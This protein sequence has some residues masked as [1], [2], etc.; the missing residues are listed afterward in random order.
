MA[1]PT[2]TTLPETPVRGEDR[3]AFATKANAFLGALPT[4]QAEANTLGSYVETKAAEVE[5]DAAQVAT[6]REAVEVA[7]AAGEGYSKT[8]VELGGDFDVGQ[9][10]KCVRVGDVVTITGVGERLTH[11]SLNTPLS[12]DGVIPV[13]FRPSF[14]V[15]NTYAVLN[16]SGL[17][18][19]SVRITQSGQLSL[20]YLSETGGVARTNSELPPTISYSKN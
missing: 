19:L 13:E 3:E 5:A 12:A 11:P 2:I 10:I 20:A 18:F 16:G 7:A 17:S 8:A 15:G 6:D 9:Q 14:L 4:F 1:A